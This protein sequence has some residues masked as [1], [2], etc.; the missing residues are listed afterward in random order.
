M[1]YIL[2]ILSLLQS[3]I[4]DTALGECKIEIFTL[5][6]KS[7]LVE[8][9]IINYSKEVISQFGPCKQS[10]Y[11][12]N[13]TNNRDDF[14]IKTNG[15]AP[16]W[17]IAITKKNPN[18]IIMQSPSTAKI[19]FKKL[20]QVLV[21]E[22]NH[23]YLNNI[24][25]S[26]SFPSW[27]K[28]G[29]AVSESGEFSINDRILISSAKW[30]NELFS[31][32]ELI[33]FRRVNKYNSRLAYAE[34]YAMFISLQ[35]YYGVDIYKNTIQLMNAGYEFWDALVITTGDKKEII[36]NNIEK[37]LLKNY[38]WIFLLNAYNLIFI[39]L[40]LILIGGYFY[41]RYKNKKLLRKWEI[42]DLLEDLYSNEEPN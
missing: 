37:F 25:N 30:K 35:S 29:M 9:T 40:P 27:F 15:R 36:E 21:H 5:S 24:K 14:N 17:G 4:I 7:I 10:P 12:I 13:I 2:L 26:H 31:L 16:E 28:E 33:T 41:K 1:I 3:N 20:L 8:E 34:S 22:L 6:H 39:F 18:R 23:V 11:I 32:N 38:N 42:E 19:S